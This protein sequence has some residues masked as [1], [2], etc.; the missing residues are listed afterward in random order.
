MT[1]KPV[2]PLPSALVDQIA[3]GEVV[4]RPASM[5]KELVENA[6]DAGSTHIRVAFQ[7]G[8]VAELSVSDNGHGM[9]PEDIRMAFKRHATSKIA[10]IDARRVP[11]AIK[12]L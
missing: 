11:A 4:E 2:L 8:G 12:A 5:A 7:D 1:P 10:T 3:A 6:I 9:S